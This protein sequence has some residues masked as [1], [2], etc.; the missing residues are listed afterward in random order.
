MIAAV[1]SD[2]DHTVLRELLAEFHDWMAVHEGDV[3]DPAREFAADVE[4]LD[5][6]RDV[7]AW[8]ARDHGDP[9]GC[10]LLYG[11]SDQV[12]EFKRLW[13]RPAARSAGLGRAL[14]RTVIEKARAEGYETLGLT[15]SPGAEA[16]H[17]LYESLGFERTGPYPETRLPEKYHDDA[18][19]MQLPL[20]EAG[21]RPHGDATG[22]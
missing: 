14:T 2:G 3:Y 20:E 21:E 12:A 5:R 7:W 10:V 13:V 8:V 1:E 17:S 6:E 11:E 4:S 16:S 9:A 22:I 19:F 18:I 15:T